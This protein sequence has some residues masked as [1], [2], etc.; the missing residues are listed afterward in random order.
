M[1]RIALSGLCRSRGEGREGRRGAEGSEGGSG[2]Q[3]RG[4]IV[5]K[6]FHGGVPQAVE[7]KEIHFLDGLIGS[8]VVQGNAV[9]G[10]ENAGAI[11]TETA[12]EEDFLPRIVAEEREKLDELFIGRRRPATD[13]NLYKTHAQGFGALALPVECLTVFAAQVNDGGD[14]ENLEFGEADVPGLGAAVKNFGDFPAVRNAINVE[15]LAK[16][17]LRKSGCGRLRDSLRRSLRKKRKRKNEKEGES[18]EVPI[19]DERSWS[20]VA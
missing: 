6:C 2:V 15:F 10:D 12:V 8:P 18:G 14:A 3:A 17:R 20:S 16:S 11:V 9:S 19:H 4:E 13:G 7:A 5:D 1:K